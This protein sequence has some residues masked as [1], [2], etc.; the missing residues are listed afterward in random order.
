MYDRGECADHRYIGQTNGAVNLGSEA[1]PVDAGLK[2]QTV[3]EYT[4]G[5]EF[6][7]RKNM[8]V[9]FRG[10]YRAQGSVI[11]DG[12]FDDGDTY[13]LFNPGEALGLGPGGPAGNT[14]FN[15][16]LGDTANG[17]ACGALDVPAVT[18]VRLSSHSTDGST[19]TSRT[20]CRMC[21]RA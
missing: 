4:A 21:S 20:T 13:F 15:A 1:T 19:R 3:N 11:E 6:G 2:P 17:R 5:F 8:V 14:E 12:S 7:F 10:I 16:C 18:I 9:G